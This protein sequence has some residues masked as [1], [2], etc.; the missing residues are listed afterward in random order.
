MN[1]SQIKEG[2]TYET[3]AGTGVCLKAGGCHPWAAVIDIKTP[4]PRGKCNVFPRDVLREVEAPTPAPAAGRGCHDKPYV[5]NYPP[6]HTWLREHEARCDWQL[7]LG[8]TPADDEHEANPNAYVE[9]WRLPTGHTFVVVVTKH[10]WDVFTS[11][12]TNDVAATLADANLR[13]CLRSDDAA[14]IDLKSLEAIK[15][16]IG[17]VD[18]ALAVLGAHG[19]IEKLVTVGAVRENLRAVRDVLDALVAGVERNGGASS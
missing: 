13:L 15:L 3:K 10:G 4:F 2:R 11:A 9:C 6:L 1:K 18:Q 5:E 16:V 7:P 19:L 8:G 17:R 12:G 14:G